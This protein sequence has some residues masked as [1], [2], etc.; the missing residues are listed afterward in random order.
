MEPNKYETII[1]WSRLK[2]HIEEQLE[3]QRSQLERADGVEAA[4]LQGDVRTLRFMLNLPNTLE[5]I[6]TTMEKQ[7]GKTGG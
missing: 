7:S 6:D 5:A 2:Q 3:A 1:P 4:R